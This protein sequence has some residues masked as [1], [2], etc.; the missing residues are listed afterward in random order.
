MSMAEQVPVQVELNR[1][2][3]Q[4]STNSLHRIVAGASHANLVTRSDYLPAVTGAV[5]QVFEAAR[6]RRS[7]QP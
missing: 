2:F 3:A 7:L 1:E 6:D 5:Q 4:L